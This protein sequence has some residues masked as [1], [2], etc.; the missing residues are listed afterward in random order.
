[1]VATA[2]RT[3]DLIV[4]ATCFMYQSGTKPQP[5]MKSG[6][7]CACVAATTMFF[8]SRPRSLSAASWSVSCLMPQSSHLLP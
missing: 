2:S 4:S 7:E 8:A 1:M 6:A 3:V 5:P